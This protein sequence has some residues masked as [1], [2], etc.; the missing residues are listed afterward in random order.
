VVEIEDFEKEVKI[1]KQIGE[2]AFGKVYKAIFMNETVA[3][4]QPIV[5][6]LTQEQLDEFIRELNILKSLPIHPNIVTLI[7]MFTKPNNLCIVTPF[8]TD[9]S[10][11][12]MLLFIHGNSALVTQIAA[13]VAT[14]MNVLHSHKI[15]HRDLAARNVLVN[16]NEKTN[17]LHFLISDFGMARP[18]KDLY[19]NANKAKQV[20]IRWTAPEGLDENKPKFVFGSDVWSFGIVLIEC[21]TG[22]SKPYPDKTIYEVV[23]F[24]KNKKGHPSRP[25]GCSDS[26]WQ[27][28]LKCWTYNADERPTFQQLLTMLPSLSF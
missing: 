8:M 6:Q 7:A 2:G 18:V 4:K 25:S 19:Y 12:K 16:R 3:V 10:L 17:K 5:H 9:G 20:P 26:G 27:F 14:G 15:I 28:L 22:N 1:K 13:E 21:L 11:D 23:Y 24:V